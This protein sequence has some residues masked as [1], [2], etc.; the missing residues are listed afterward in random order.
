MALAVMSAVWWLAPNPAAGQG[1]EAAPTDFGGC[2]ATPPGFHTCAL[3]KA[4]TFTPPRT[5]D[6]KP[7]FQGF[8]RG[9]L[10]PT[11]SVEGVPDTEPRTRDLIGPWRVA[12][13]SIMDPPDGKIPYQPW[14]AAVGRKGRN[15]HKYIDPRTACASGGVPRLMEMQ[16]QILQPTGENFVMWIFEDH[17]VHR[18]IA[19]D[20]RPHVGENIKL[21]NGDSVGRWEG[22]TFVV[23]VANFNGYSWLDDSANFYTDAAHMVERLTMIDLNTLHYQ[24]TI[25]DPKAYTRPWTMAWAMVRNVQPGFELLEEACREGE[26]DLPKFLELGYVYYF[27]NNLWQPS[28]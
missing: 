11:F 18:A 4:K 27:R 13:S 12:P 3:E 21:L 20:G 8:W 9:R 7:D 25:D 22:N 2:P 16:S 1:G 14:A 17:N 23:D 15:F 24:I 19:T 26:R 10:Y 28:K 5:P 6:G